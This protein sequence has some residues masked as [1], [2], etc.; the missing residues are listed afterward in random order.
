MLGSQPTPL[1]KRSQQNGVRQSWR[2]GSE[3][4]L[5][6]EA[7][8]PIPV[9]IHQ[10]K[11]GQGHGYRFQCNRVS[12]NSTSVVCPPLMTSVVFRWSRWLFTVPLYPSG[13]H[14]SLLHQLTADDIECVV[15][16]PTLPSGVQVRLRSAE[17][18]TPKHVAAHHCTPYVQAKST[19]SSAHR[20]RKRGVSGGIAPSYDY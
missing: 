16:D 5:S 4:Q 19:L 10:N 8:R 18:A 15:D 7:K 9:G 1:C 6:C 20:R 13:P 3:L 11:L 14:S 17:V 12:M 2:C